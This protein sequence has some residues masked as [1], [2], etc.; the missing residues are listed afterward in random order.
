[1]AIAPRSIHSILFPE[2]SI[3]QH[4]IQYSHQASATKPPEVLT[5]AVLA[6]LFL[7]PL[8]SSNRSLFVQNSATVLK[9]RG[10]ASQNSSIRPLFFL[11]FKIL[12]LL[13][14]ER[15]NTLLF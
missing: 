11:F 3:R 7:R 14:K 1:M 10:F 13:E 4:L 5:L 8:F 9:H 2:I 12:A 15:Q 6:L